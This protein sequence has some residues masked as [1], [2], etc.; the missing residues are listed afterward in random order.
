MMM[1]EY[2]MSSHQIL[3][4][5]DTN[6]NVVSVL[7]NNGPT[8]AGVM[9]G[10][11][12][13]ISQPF[14]QSAVLNALSLTEWAESLPLLIA[15][16]VSFMLAI[17][18]TLVMQRTRISEALIVVP[19]VTGILFGMSL[20]AN[21][22]TADMINDSTNV[23]QDTSKDTLVSEQKKQ[24]QKQL[25]DL[26]K[27]VALLD[28]AS[29]EQQAVNS[30][31]TRGI[32]GMDGLLAVTAAPSSELPAASKSI[33][34]TSQTSTDQKNNVDQK[35]IQ[36]QIEELHKKMQALEKQQRKPKPRSL[37]RSW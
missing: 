23:E 35:K 29:N 13:A 3:G 21:H 12:N 4:N 20:G 36:R 7:F 1:R 27:Q 33:D 25:N 11:V 2:M 10:I 18:Q 5:K 37:Y 32:P 22:L 15:I 9:V 31:K 17:Y 19:L 24:L 30:R 8:Q 16:V 6:S 14:S 26:Q 34:D 28:V